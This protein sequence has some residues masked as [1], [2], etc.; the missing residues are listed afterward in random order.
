MKNILLLFALIIGISSAFSQANIKYQEIE[1]HTY[2]FTYHNNNK[3][4][5]KE[6]VLKLEDGT[7]KSLDFYEIYDTDGNLIFKGNKINGRQ[8]TYYQNGS[9]KTQSMISNSKT[10]GRKVFFNK[11]GS[12]LR[13]EIYTSGILMNDKKK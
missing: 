1:G 10:E 2:K 12:I 11:D 9:K 6:Q 4:E 3:L 5:V 7:Y 13:V 8:I